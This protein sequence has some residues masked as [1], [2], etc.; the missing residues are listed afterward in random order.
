MLHSK[1]VLSGFSPSFRL[2]P[3][4]HFAPILKSCRDMKTGPCFGVISRERMPGEKWVPGMF[5]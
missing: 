4:L 1:N 5:F 2:R 3:I